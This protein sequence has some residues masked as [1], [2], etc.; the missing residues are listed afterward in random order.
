MIDQNLNIRVMTR[1]ELDYAIEWAAEEGW[2]PGLYDADSFYSADPGGFLIGS[3]GNKPV[4]CVS[5]VRYSK[6]FIFVGFFLVKKEY[7]GKKYAL[8]LGK[9]VLEYLGDR[10]VGIDGVVSKQFL[11]KLIGFKL[12]FRSFRFM[13]TGGI[14]DYQDPEIVSLDK[15]PLKVFYRYDRPFF[16]TDRKRFIKNWIRQKE[17]KSMA[18]IVDN[19]I[20]GYGVIRPCYEGYKI[21]PLFADNKSYAKRIFQNLISVVPADTHYYLDIPDAN[22]AGISLAEDFE[23]VPVFQTARMYRG[24]MPQLPMDRIFGITSFEL[25]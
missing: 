7:R 14:Q 6:D 5:A 10:V 15:M 24:D 25:G 18:L 11:Y 1:A 13:G 2:N 9:K 23:M 16:P 8:L 17:S 20:V 12:A 4:C 21:G 22:S 3:I 19:K